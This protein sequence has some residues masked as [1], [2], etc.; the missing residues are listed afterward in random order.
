MNAKEELSRLLFEATTAI[1]A[2]MANVEFGKDDRALTKANKF[3][4]WLVEE[5]NKLNACGDSQAQG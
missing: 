3:R 1:S 5:Q 4:K 2:V